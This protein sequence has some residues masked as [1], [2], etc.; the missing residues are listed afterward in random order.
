MAVCLEISRSL[1]SQL[2]PQASY[3]YN[4]VIY[5]RQKRKKGDSYGIVGP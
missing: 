5:E 1:E 3:Q 4:E 2:S